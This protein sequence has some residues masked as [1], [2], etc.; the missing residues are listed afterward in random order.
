[1]KPALRLA[2]LAGLAGGCATPGK[3]AST[4]PTSSPT[5]Q[6]LTS[7]ARIPLD[8]LSPALT[9]ATATPTTQESRPPIDALE[10][11]AQ[12]REAQLA[13][14]RFTAINLLEKALELDPQSV[15]LN[16][17][18]GRAY[19]TS[20]APPE[21]GIAAFEKTREIDPQNLE[22]YV[23]LARAYQTRNDN[24]STINRLRLA[25]L[26]AAYQQNDPLAA[27]V[28]YRLGVALQQEGY[29]QG[30]VESYQ[31]LVQRLQH[32]NVARSSPEINF[33]VARPEA[34]F[35]EMAKLYEKLGNTHAAFEIY[36]TIAEQSPTNFDAQQ[37]V[38]RALLKLDRAEEAQADATQLVRQFHAS[39]ESLSLLKETVEARRSGSFIAALRRLHNDQPKDRAILFALTDTL[40]ADGKVPQAR[41]LLA[42]AIEQDQSDVELIERAWKLEVDQGQ[43][44]A[45]ATLLITASANQPQITSELSPLF[46]NLLSVNRA[47][48]LR[49]PTI[50]QLS[51]P[52][53]AEPARQFWIS[54]TAKIWQRS[55]LEDTSLQKA[56]SADKT[57]DPAIRMLLTAHLDKAG[58]DA[59]KAAFVDQL[60]KSVSSKG[61]GDLALELRGLWALQ[62]KQTDEAIR[63]FTQSQAAAKVDSPDVQLELALALNAS[64]NGPRFEQA[65][66]KLI[67]DHPRFDETYSILV[68]YYKQADAQDK[69]SSVVEKWLAA[70]PNSANARLQQVADLIQQR[71]IDDAVNAMLKLFSQMPDNGQ[72]IAGTVSLLSGMNQQD[73]LVTLLESERA[74][75]PSNVLVVDSLVD[76][77]TSQKNASAAQA[78][79]SATR[80]AVANDP[81]LLY[82]LAS[83]YQRVSDNEAAE[84]VLLDVLKV[85]PDDP[86]ASND[87][88]YTWA[89]SGKNLEKAEK[90]IRRAVD[91]EPDNPSYLD[92]LGWVLYKRGQFA[93]ARTQLDAAVKPTESADPVVLDHFGDALYRLDQKV[94]AM[95]AWQQSLERLKAVRGREDLRDLPAKLRMKLQQAKVGHVVDVAPIVG[96]QPANPQSSSSHELGDFPPN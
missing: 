29:D 58:T 51:L 96:Q 77:Y 1:M 95:Q 90:F 75:H 46:V 27:V 82:Y 93:D 7:N 5:T 45:A 72:V 39:S 20:G 25:R 69:A 32:G 52:A 81:D 41:K 74:R 56:A 2:L 68:S 94:Q 50:Q 91:A 10:L 64:G 21:R 14:Q 92:S 78:D 30:A 38:I 40:A 15:E 48:A 70:A 13:N 8:R 80:K 12:A 36:Q 66:W 76:I 43:L 59:D 35:N 71:R 22:A 87:L 16:A 23:E 6:P 55:I 88:G 73:R 86:Q 79:L 67:S 57:F 19:L 11:F 31:N 18:L 37:R 34:L 26:T 3:L 85:Q 49:L 65:M 24:A 89:D 28:D 62:S 84:A 63:L 83:L 9:L 53:S 61:R 42:E 33:L 17:A 44:A 54:R 4:R 60:A 47:G